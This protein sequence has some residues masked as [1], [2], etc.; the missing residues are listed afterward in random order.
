LNEGI[1]DRDSRNSLL[2]L[3]DFRRAHHR[4][5]IIERIRGANSTPTR[6]HREK[7]ALLYDAWGKAEKAAEMREAAKPAAAAPVEA[8]KK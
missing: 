6:R 4:L 7:M 3:D 1:V 8:G 2:Q 5:E